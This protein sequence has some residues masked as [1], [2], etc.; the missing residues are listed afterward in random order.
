MGSVRDAVGTAI[1]RLRSTQSPFDREAIPVAERLGFSYRG[2]KATQDA[3]YA[4]PLDPSIMP[5]YRPYCS[6]LMQGSRHG[7]WAMIFN[8]T[9]QKE[10]GHLPLI[11]W[12][13]SDSDDVER[14]VFRYTCAVVKSHEL[15]P[16]CLVLPRTL[17]SSFFGPP[18]YGFSA[19]R[20]IEGVDDWVIATSGP[21]F[22]PPVPAPALA[23][24]LTSVTPGWHFRLRD[25]WFVCVA[26]GLEPEDLRPYRWIE[27]LKTVEAFAARAEGLL[28]ALV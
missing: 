14:Y 1:S 22:Q 2:P 17:L 23:E 25:Q 19:T 26:G 6:A 13:I 21:F 5:R 4:L 27:P 8:C 10:P 24:W 12:L 16:D 3:D 20:E 11:K 15:L 9:S 7:R 18:R 28:A